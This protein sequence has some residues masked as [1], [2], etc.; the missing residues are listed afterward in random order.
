MLRFAWRNLLTRPLRTALAMV[1]LSIPILGVIGLFSLSHALRNL[2]GDTLSQIQGVMI[3]RDNALSPVFSDL[4]LDYADR[5]RSVPGVARVAPEVWKI[6]PRIENKGLFSRAARGALGSLGGKSEEAFSSLFDT[7]V[8]LGQ[9]TPSHRDLKSAVFPKAMVKGPQGG[10]FLNES[11]AGQKRIVISTKLARDFPIAD[12]QNPAQKRPRKVGDSILIDD[13]PFEIVGLYET[14]SMLLD[15]V[16]VMDIATAR[17]LLNVGADK[18]SC[19]YVEGNDPG[20]AEELAL[21]IEA[22]IPGTDARGMNEVMQNFGTLMNQLDQFLLMTVSL[23]L[24][25]GVV[26][27]VNTMLM[28]T[29]ERVGE[30]GVL[31]T[32]G[33]SR[34]NVLALITAESAYLGLLS[35]LIGCALALLGITLANQILQSS[36]LRLAVTPQ[37]ILLGVG[38]AVIM[39]TLGGIYPAWRASRL[40]PMEAIRLGSS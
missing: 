36:G 40:V 16:I 11:D 15:V 9:D 23:A 3:V 39:G 17:Q 27:I 25:V 21:R 5:I 33:W 6:A 38:L 2:V 18:V 30:F 8:I 35:G 28:S 31:R 26:G 10:R 19:F 29:T 37:I 7:P 20:S 4:P 22:A 14:G 32:N 24:F 13:Q 34:S 1:G 12:P